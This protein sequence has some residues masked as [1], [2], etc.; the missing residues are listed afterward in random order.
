VD[1]DTPYDIR[2]VITSLADRGEFFELQGL[3]AANIVIGLARLD[4]QAVGIVANN[5]LVESGML[6]ANGCD[7]AARF[8]RTCDA[9]NIPLIFL[10][11]TPGFLSSVQ[12]E[13]SQEGL[14]RHAAKSIYAI[15]ESTVPKVTVYLRRCFGAGRLIMG[16]R[17][18]GVDAAFA[19]PQAK[20]SLEEAGANGWPEEPFFSA[21]QM[22]VDDI[23]DPRE[24]R[25]VLVKTLKRLA[26]KQQP[27]RPWKKQGLIPL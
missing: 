19:W 6:D 17:E 5:P 1:P 24:T 14:E 18:M 16:S 8:I 10:V 11:D 2:P 23:I 27:E 12:Q 21:G 20:I 15:C 9:F 4:G 7:K 26:K 25:Q 13:Q 3:Y 22:V